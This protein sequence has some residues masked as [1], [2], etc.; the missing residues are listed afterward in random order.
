[1]TQ[2]TP[3]WRTTTA[4]NDVR[5]ASAGAGDPLLAAKAAYLNAPFFLARMAVILAVWMVFGAALRRR[6]HVAMFVGTSPRQ[7]S[8]LDSSV[9]GPRRRSRRAHVVVV[10]TAAAAR[11][12]MPIRSPRLRALCG[13]ATAAALAASASAAKAAEEVGAPESHAQIQEVI[14]LE[15]T[16]VSLALTQAPA[17]WEGGAAPSRVQA[18]P[19]GVIRLL[20]HRWTHAYIIPLAAGVY[21]SVGTS[22]ARN[23][24]LARLQTEAGVIVPGTGRRLELGLAAGTGMLAMAY[25]NH[26]DG[27]CVIGG[28]GLIASPVA[29]YLFRDGPAVTVGASVRAIIPLAEPHGEG[30]GWFTGYGSILL[31]AVEFGFGISG[32]RSTSSPGSS[33][34]AG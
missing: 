12:V 18:G 6:P 33:V 32:S 23:T 28:R 9:V 15:L 26:C 27:T 29:R 8:V 31:G 14:G 5:A 30:W 1:M 21:V 7:R 17:S 16:P 13:L 10:G 19:G 24:I 11:P 34:Q 3:G 4:S 2:G 20:R 22:P 25:G